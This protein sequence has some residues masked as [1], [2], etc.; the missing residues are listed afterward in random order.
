MD[1]ATTPKS[2]SVLSDLVRRV[3]SEFLEMPG[4][5]LTERQ[6]QRL[7]GLDPRYCSA[8][9]DTLRAAGFLVRTKDGYFMRLDRA[10]AVKADLSQLPCR[11]TKTSA[12]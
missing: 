4:L 5:R 8:V 11:R 1:P 9:L 10:Q 6:L 3:Q 2:S 7:S 12:A